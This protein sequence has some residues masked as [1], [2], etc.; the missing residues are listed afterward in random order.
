MIPPKA[1]PHIFILSSSR[2]NKEGFLSAIG[3]LGVPMENG[4]GMKPYILVEFNPNM[5]VLD[6][7]RMEKPQGCLEN[8]P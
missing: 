4:E 7:E 2:T 5:L 8:F 1:F 3:S 6:V